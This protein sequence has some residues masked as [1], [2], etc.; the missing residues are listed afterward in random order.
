MI[1]IITE[2]VKMPDLHQRRYQL[3]PH[4]ANYK[5]Q[6]LDTNT[7]TS[8]KEGTFEEMLLA[9]LHLNKGYY[10]ENPI[11]E[12]VGIKYILHPMDSFH[13]FGKFRMVGGANV[14]ADMVIRCTGHLEIYDI[15]GKDP[16]IIDSREKGAIQNTPFPKAENTSEEF[17]IT[18]TPFSDFVTRLFYDATNFAD[19]TLNEE[20]HLTI[21]QLVG[22]SPTIN[23]LRENK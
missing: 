23:D 7:G 12:K 4:F 20:G 10:L 22:T 11:S 17:K 13:R 18:M 14:F 16:K 3:M 15:Q 2:D 9:R 8:I 1:K 19:I 5:W 6:V 21:H